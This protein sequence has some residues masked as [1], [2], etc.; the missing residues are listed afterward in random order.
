MFYTTK[1]NMIDKNII[2]SISCNLLEKAALYIIRNQKC[3]RHVGR[4]RDMEMEQM[5]HLAGEVKEE[6][7]DIENV[8]QML[9]LSLEM[10]E[11]EEAV[12]RSVR[13]VRKMIRSLSDNAASGFQALVLDV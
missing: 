6:L 13:I 4:G 5:K 11:E 10:N 2:F 3:E 7:E 8:L 9:E 1:W 12:R